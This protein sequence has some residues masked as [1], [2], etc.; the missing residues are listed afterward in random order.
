MYT[1]YQGSLLNDKHFVAK[2][3]HVLIFFNKPVKTDRF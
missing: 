1:E 3:V 2:N